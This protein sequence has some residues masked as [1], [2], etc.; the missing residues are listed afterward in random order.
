M[1]SM[2][3]LKV[4][5]LSTVVVVV[6]CSEPK[7]Y[8]DL[9]SEVSS[10]QYEILRLRDEIEK[11]STDLGEAKESID[12]LQR[13]VV[14]GSVQL[15]EQAQKIEKIELKLSFMEFQIR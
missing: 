3:K 5:A 8:R 15:D 10:L 4:L 13:N 6:G 14:A 9:Q 1:S 2:N 12:K 11:L 7:R